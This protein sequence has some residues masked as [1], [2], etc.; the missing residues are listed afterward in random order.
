MKNKRP[1]YGD[2]NELNFKLVLS[3]HKGTQCMQRREAAYIK[4]LTGLS[5]M[6]FFVLEALY[7]KG[8]LCVK[9]IKEITNATG[10]NLTV[11][12]KNLER[13]GLIDRV[14]DP[15][16]RRRLALSLTDQG[17]ELIKELFEKHVVHLAE[18]TSVLT[19]DE[20]Q[21]LIRIMKKLG[22]YN[23]R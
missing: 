17:R 6:Q 22:R 4:E 12:I 16:D 8:D 2:E 7:H 18:L 20:K 23:E 19:T 15:A 10:G 9:D 21:E 1:H 14:E 13:D 11:V 3:L 5:M